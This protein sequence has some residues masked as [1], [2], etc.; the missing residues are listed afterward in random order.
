PLP[1]SDYEL[2]P[3]NEFVNYFPNEPFGDENLKENWPK[4]NPV[5]DENF[6]TEKSE[7]LKINPKKWKEGYYI[8]RGFILDGKDTI[9]HEKLVY[10][11]QNEKSNPIDNEIFSINLNQNSYKPGETAVLNLA[12]A[13]ENSE[14]LV[15]LE[16]DGKIVKSEKI[17]LNKN[18]KKFSFPIDEKYRGNVF[19]HYYFGKFN[20]TK[21]G[22][23][24]VNVPFEDKSLKITAATLRDKL[25]PGQKETWELTVSGK[26]K[27][28]FLAEML[29]TMYDAS[30]DQFKSNSNN[31]PMGMNENYS[32]LRSW[33]TYRSFGTNSFFTLIENPFK[34]YYPQNYL[35][36]S[37]LN[38]FGFG[39]NNYENQIYG[40][41][42]KNYDMAGAPGAIA[43][44]RLSGGIEME[45]AEM[46]VVM[47]EPKKMVSY[48][49]R[50]DTIQY[51][52]DI[53]KD[54]NLIERKKI[55]L[56]KIVARR[57]LQETAFFYPNLKTDKNGN[58]KIQF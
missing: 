34:Y 15:Q 28:K 45:A 48:S 8:L 24:T 10:L 17:K 4:E 35:T 19:L 11:Y 38:W 7:S 36:F 47:P 22:T 32:S 58:V 49:N 2:Y 21:S 39:W 25:Q 43:E 50:V 51:E 27:D 12:S 30:L 13:T 46:K 5:L 55:D 53:D 18:V 56:N 1:Q 26:D 44:V 3:K 14:V 33:D 52:F 9:P 16:S 37:E 31:F 23:L 6:D 41:R 20:T 57:A 40:S 42:A 54:G 29:A